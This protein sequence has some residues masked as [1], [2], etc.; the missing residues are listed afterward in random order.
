MVKCFGCEAS[1]GYFENDCTGDTSGV[2]LWSQSQGFKNAGNRDSSTFRWQV[3]F[4]A[5]G[6]GR[7]GINSGSNV[8]I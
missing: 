1:C 6:G 3:L 2:R 5:M 7:L 4:Q 8:V